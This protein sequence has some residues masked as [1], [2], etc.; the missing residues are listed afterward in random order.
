MVVPGHGVAAQVAE[1]VPAPANRRKQ[2]GTLICQSLRLKITVVGV[3][4]EGRREVQ[5]LRYLQAMKVQPST[6][7]RRSS[8]CD[9][10][11]ESMTVEFTDSD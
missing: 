6:L 9:E 2:T 10:E 5:L 3:L 11:W 8:T 1:A 7:V 4:Q